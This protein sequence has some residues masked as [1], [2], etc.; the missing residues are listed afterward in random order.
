MWGSSAARFFRSHSWRGQLRHACLTLPSLLRFW[1]NAPPLQWGTLSHGSLTSGHIAITSFLRVTGCPLF[2]AAPGENVQ[3]QADQQRHINAKHLGLG[4]L[5]RCSRSSRMPGCRHRQTPHR[6]L[7]WLSQNGSHPGF[8]P[9]DWHADVRP[10]SG[11]WKCRS[12]AQKECQ[13]I[14][15]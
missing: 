2:A 12:A 14:I 11:R 10:P 6:Y 7:R 3:R 8:L 1:G 9:P 15:Y 4:M 5:F 13:Q